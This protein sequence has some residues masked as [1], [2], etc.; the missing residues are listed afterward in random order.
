MEYSDINRIL[1]ILS[2]S[3]ADVITELDKGLLRIMRF[4]IIDQYKIDKYMKAT[5]TY[6]D[7]YEFSS[8]A[9]AI[10]IQS[11]YYQMQTIIT[12]YCNRENPYDMEM[13]QII[14]KIAQ[15]N[16]VFSDHLKIYDALDGPLE[17]FKWKGRQNLNKTLKK[18]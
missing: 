6:G 16:K 1:K 11:L 3:E 18:C 4:Q 9:Q 5:K 10:L 2:E 17:F 8:R 13:P 15:S 14:N 7:N 12:K